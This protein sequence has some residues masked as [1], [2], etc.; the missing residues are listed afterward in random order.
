M[1]L[2]KRAALP[3][4]RPPDSNLQDRKTQIL[5]A[6]EQLFTDHGYAGT[7]IRNIADSAGVN[8]ALVHYYFGNKHAL[9]QT[10]LERSL[11]PMAGA[12]AVLKD[13]K[14]ASIEDIAS[15][16]VSM[17][18]AQPNIPRLLAR[19]VLLPGGEMQDYFIEHLAPQLGGALPALLEREKRAGKLRDDIDPA[20]SALMVLAVCFFPF[21]ARTLAEPVLGISLGADGAATL[22]KHVSD[23]LKQGMAT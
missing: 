10:V 3:A 19:E 13:G 1:K 16:L 17:A 4:G 21:I 14:E 11:K 5:D 20:Y 18:A 23:L 6:A 8:P 2:L 9:L 12:L 7:S 22:I 15:L